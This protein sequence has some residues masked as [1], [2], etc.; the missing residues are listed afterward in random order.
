MIMITIHTDAEALTIEGKSCDHIADLL[1][2]V[3][4][5]FRLARGNVGSHRLDMFGHEV[6]SVS[7]TDYPLTDEEVE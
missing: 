4:S 7:V 1:H 5:K 3:A 6:G 2:D